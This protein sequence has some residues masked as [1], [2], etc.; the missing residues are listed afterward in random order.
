MGEGK[1][2]ALI[3][4]HRKIH[5]KSEWFPSPQSKVTKEFLEYIASIFF[6]AATLL[7]ALYDTKIN[8]Q[9][10]MYKYIKTTDWRMI[11]NMNSTPWYHFHTQPYL[12]LSVSYNSRIIQF[13]ATLI[14]ASVSGVWLHHRGHRK[15]YLISSC[16]LFDPLMINM[17]P[18]ILVTILVGT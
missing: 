13:R 2:I 16:Y 3:F 7:K 11:E 6:S 1:S 4:S 10:A 5:I 9:W 15:V 14:L 18:S 8:S 12:K 17:K